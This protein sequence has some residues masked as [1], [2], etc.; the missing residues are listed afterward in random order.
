MV[1]GVVEIELLM[2]ENDSLKAKRSIIKRVINRTRSH[3]NVTMAEVAKQNVISRGVVG[4][5]IVGS[6]GRYINGTL[7]KVVNFIEGL[8]LAEI[9]EARI[10]IVHF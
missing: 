1:L 2:P 7:D 9:L 10:E 3:F 6:D 8:S 4:C 5:A